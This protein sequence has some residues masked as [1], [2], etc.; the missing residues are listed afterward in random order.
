ME[1]LRSGR[2]RY[3]GMGRL[4]QPPTTSRAN[5]EYTSSRSWR[6]VLRHVG[7]SNHGRI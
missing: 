1:E 4:V 5:R 6:A 3:F 7:R 2:V